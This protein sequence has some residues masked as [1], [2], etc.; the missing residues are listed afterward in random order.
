MM[1]IMVEIVSMRSDHHY[2]RI[3]LDPRP[4]ALFVSFRHLFYAN[5]YQTIATPLLVAL[6]LAL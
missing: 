6:V 5:L 3:F 2:H 4:R 1:Y